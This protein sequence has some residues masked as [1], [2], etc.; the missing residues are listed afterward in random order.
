MSSRCDRVTQSPRILCWIMNVLRLFIFDA[1]SC[2][3]LLSW[4]DRGN[5]FDIIWCPHQSQEMRRE[6]HLVCVSLSFGALGSRS[7][8]LFA[9]PS[10]SVLDQDPSVLRQRRKKVVSWLS[11]PVINFFIAAPPTCRALHGHQGGR[12]CLWHGPL[13]RLRSTPRA[14]PK[15]VSALWRMK[16]W[17]WLYLFIYLFEPYR[18]LLRWF[19]APLMRVAILKYAA[20]IIL[21]VS[22]NLSDS[23]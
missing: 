6:S 4:P 12:Q 16:M 9:F 7:Q 20:F 14:R 11:F 22:S 17:M 21:T 18:V 23:D 13:P 1:R 8:D 19:A 5:W 2:K 3:L 15:E 10:D